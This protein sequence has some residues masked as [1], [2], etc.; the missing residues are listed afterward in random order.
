VHARA[1]DRDPVLVCDKP[2]HQGPLLQELDRSEVE[3]RDLGSQALET[4]HPR[5]SWDNHLEADAARRQRTDAKHAV[6]S[7]A[8]LDRRTIPANR[9]G[10]LVQVGSR[11]DAGIH[12]RLVLLVNYSAKDSDLAVKNDVAQVVRAAGEDR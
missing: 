1:L 6:D 8:R 4:T 12:D 2:R 10:Q 7:G 11:R 9:V 5:L 3:L